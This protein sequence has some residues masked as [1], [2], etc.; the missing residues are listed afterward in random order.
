[1]QAAEATLRMRD[2]CPQSS[3]K[4]HWTIAAI[5][6]MRQVPGSTARVRELREELRQLQA[7]ALD[8][9]TAH[10]W[11]MDVS[12]LRSTTVD[13]FETVALSDAIAMLIEM[14]A[15]P[16]V[17]D[18][19]E[20]ARE[21]AKKTPLGSLF[22]SA[23]LDAQG[24]EVA[25]TKPLSFDGDPDDDWY[26]AEAAK[27]MDFVAVEHV[28]GRIEPGRRTLLMRFAIAER[29]VAPIVGNSVFVPTG[30]GEILAVGLAR[31]FQGDYLTACHLLFPQLENILRHILVIHGEDPSKIAPDL[32]QGDRALGALLDVDRASLV[33]LLGDDTIHLI[34]I[35]FNFRPGPSLRNE[36][37]HG[38]LP[39]GA[40]YS[41]FA[42]YGCW[43]I[44]WL[45]VLPLRPQWRTGIAPLIEEAA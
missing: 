23:H 27:H 1:M 29:H 18:L 25:R 32:L 35:L 14:G 22:G 31:M 7:A 15:P 34:D 11:S 4:A 21:Q 39:W 24:R 16:S 5:S 10:R 33:T 38:K 8:E 40:F 30:R 6:E 28:N 26:K 42:I 44:L 9:F 41:H 3:A 43:F 13:R 2:D 12:D 45:I 17:D 36:L 20:I 37:A 19:R